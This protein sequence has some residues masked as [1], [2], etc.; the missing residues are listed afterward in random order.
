MDLEK[1]RDFIIT[2]KKKGYASNRKPKEN[3]D[4]SKTLVYKKKEWKYIDNW[5]GSNRFGGE[6]VVLFNGLRVW[7][8]C[9]H[10]G[11]TKQITS[12]S[13]IFNF[14]KKVLSKVPK[15]KPF[16]GPPSFKQEDFEYKNF[17]IGNLESFH[18]YEIITYRGETLY[19][20]EYFGGILLK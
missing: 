3:L 15:D 5:C 11:I 2:A 13:S 9:Y 18:G 20:T 6:E 16:R 12:P 14:L 17:P 4:G 7:H 8:M 10:G 19:Y 1:L